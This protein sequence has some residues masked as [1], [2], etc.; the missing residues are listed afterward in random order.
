MS[1]QATAFSALHEALTRARNYV[2][3]MKPRVMSLV[4]FTSL[5][6]MV[7]SPLQAVAPLEA[8]IALVLI[9]LGAGASGALNM[10]F[11]SDIDALMARTRRR[12]VPSGALSCDEAKYFGLILS[13]ASCLALWLVTNGF[14]AFLLAFT[15]A[16]YAGFYTLYL[17]R[18][19]DQNIVI[20]GLA[21]ALPPLIGEVAVTGTFSGV[22]LSLVLIIFLW[23][24]PHFWAL[25]VVRREDYARAQVPML[26]CVAPA[27]TVVYRTRVYGVVTIIA[28]FLPVALGEAGWVYFLGSFLWGLSFLFALWRFRLTERGEI[29]KASALHLF[30]V[31]I[32]YLFALFATLLIDDLTAFA[33]LIGV[34]A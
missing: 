23:T 25:A 7:V 16:F 4:V 6:G 18:R 28:S 32:F 13:V 12:P 29:D 22:G 26:P 33:P 8:L 1:G 19:S 11:D 20:G 2:Q 17:K 27:S 3:L 9:A 31:S 15:I 21:G 24:P 34:A 10:A 5:V 30:S 14:A